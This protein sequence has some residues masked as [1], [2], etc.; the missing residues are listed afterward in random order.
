MYNLIFIY[1]KLVRFI[2]LPMLN[3]YTYVLTYI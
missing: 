1:K 2:Y 3:A